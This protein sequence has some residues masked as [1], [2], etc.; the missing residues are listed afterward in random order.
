MAYEAV[1]AKVNGR[2]ERVVKIAESLGRMEAISCSA[3][4]YRMFVDEH[5]ALLAGLGVVIGRMPLS[6]VMTMNR[7]ARH[8]I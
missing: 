4:V 3:E 6:V 5:V 2:K 1:L 7:V 8:L